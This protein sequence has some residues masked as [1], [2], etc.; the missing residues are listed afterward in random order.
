MSVHQSELFPALGGLAYA[1]DAIGESDERA[2]IASIEALN[3]APF[4]FQRWLGKRLTASFGWHYDFEHSRM[5]QTHPIPPWLKPLRIEAARFARL[6][7]DDLAHVLVTH[8][9]PGAGIG[10][11]RDRPVFDH[12]IGVSLGASAALRF[13]RKTGKKFDRASL[14]CRPRSIYHL[15]GEARRVW[16]HSI[17]PIDAPRWSITFRSLSE[18][19]L[20]SLS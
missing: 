17:I 10:W 14:V 12:V 20:R 11:H 8:Y 2:L 9:P 18:K 15:S 16:E 7:P 1:D 5:G 4:R 13:R 19:H 6:A 3:L